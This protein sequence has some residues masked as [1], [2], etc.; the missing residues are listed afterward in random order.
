MSLFEIY[1]ACIAVEE[2]RRLYLKW[3]HVLDFKIS[4]HLKKIKIE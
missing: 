1:R 3:V 4:W 2:K